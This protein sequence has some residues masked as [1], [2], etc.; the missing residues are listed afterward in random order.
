MA[1]SNIQYYTYHSGLWNYQGVGL[2]GCWVSSILQPNI[3]GIIYRYLKLVC[4][5][6]RVYVYSYVCGVVYLCVWCS[7]SVCCVVY[8]CI[9]IFCVCMFVCV[10]LYEHAWGACF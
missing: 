10:L 4:L 7:V 3:I 5:Y 2:H 1:V 8:L 9:R 6:V